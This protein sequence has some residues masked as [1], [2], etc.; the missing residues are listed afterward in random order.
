MR[1]R[2]L[3][4]RKLDRMLD[5]IERAAD[6]IATD[7]AIDECNDVDAETIAHRRGLAHGLRLARATFTDKIDGIA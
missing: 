2:F 4:R 7:A 5:E 1:L 6:E 3:T